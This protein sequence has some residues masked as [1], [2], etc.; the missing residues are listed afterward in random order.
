MSKNFLHICVSSN[1]SH[2]Q[3]GAIDVRGRLGLHLERV[4]AREVRYKENINTTKNLQLKKCM[5]KCTVVDVHCHLK[6]KHQL[7]VYYLLK[8]N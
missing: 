7:D 6:L 8:I 2:T 4:T 3:F 1:Y 5:K